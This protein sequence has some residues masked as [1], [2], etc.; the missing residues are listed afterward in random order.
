MR[1]IKEISFEA[2]KVTLF[3]WNQKFILKFEKYH[4][5]Q[6]FKISEL[7]VSQEEVEE[8]LQNDGFVKKVLD[9]FEEMYQDWNETLNY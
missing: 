5:E 7:D 3:A 6:T 2:F 4:L 9:R 1:V 8:I